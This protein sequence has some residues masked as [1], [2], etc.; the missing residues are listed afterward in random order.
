[1][2]QWQ[3]VPGVELSPEQMA[4]L[5]SDIVW[6]VQKK[7]TL[8]SG[9]TR[10]VLV[11]QVYVRVQESDLNGSG[12]LIAGQRLNLNIAGDLVNSGSLAGRSVMAITAQNIENLGGRIQA[13]KVS[14]TARENLDNLGGLIGATDSLAINAGQNVNVVSSSRDSSSAQGTRT[15]L[16]RVAGL[17]VSGAGGTMGVN[18][19]KDLNL[20]GAQ[21]VNAGTGG[22]TSLQAG[23]N[24][25]LT[26]VGEAHQ[27]SVNWNG[28]NWRKDASQTEVGS[29]IQGQ[30]DVRLSAGQDLNARGASVTSQQGAIIADAGR[31]VN[32][33]AAQNTQFA[34]EAHKFKGSNGLFS[35][36]TTTTRDT[37]NQTQ[38]QG[39]TLS[40]EKTYVQ[41]GRDINVSGSN[42]V[43]TNQTVLAAD[44]NI[45]IEAAT[46][47][48]S[49][50]HDKSVKKSGLFSG[51]GIAVTLG[52]QQQTVKDLTTSQTA[53]ASTVGSTK[54]DV[55]ME[56]GK[57][58]RQVGSQVSAPEGSVD[59]TGQTID[60]VE[61][62]NTS[63]RERETLFKQTGFT[64]TVTNPV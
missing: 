14:L 55:L 63:K 28:S 19:G 22:S 46:E 62:R 58:Y 30:G 37:V 47:S 27:Q 17:F 41:A 25:N 16:S 43:S 53:A 7:V 15:N 39:S 64:L 61:A 20:T 26:T 49:E 21:V 60:V 12:S 8:A 44:N 6:L 48:S 38:A 34:D 36:K 59:I 3:L 50:R 13:D 51:G 57:G 11:P 54:G 42:V 1:A 35:S 52:T 29:T 45:N 9:E 56:A 24:I 10:N 23:N 40:A 32:L 31:D 5:T 2:N 18:A 4:Q 33:T